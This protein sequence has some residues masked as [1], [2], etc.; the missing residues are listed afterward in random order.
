MQS[1]HGVFDV[2]PGGVVILRVV[3]E[4]AAERSFLNTH[5]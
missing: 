1:T 2:W 4:L 5:E 3:V